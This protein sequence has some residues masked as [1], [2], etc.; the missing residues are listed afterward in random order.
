V[1][2]AMHAAGHRLL[3]FALKPAPVQVTWLSYPGSTGMQ[4]IDYRLT[5]PQLDPP[6][7]NDAW[8]SEKSVHLPRTYWCYRSPSDAPEVNELPALSAGRITFGCLNNFNKVNEV[9]LSAWCRLL[10][11]LPNA[12]LLLHAK[13]GSHR[14]KVRDKLARD[15]IDPARLEFIGRVPV[16]EY[17]RCYHRIDIA[18][19]TF[20][21]CGGTTT[22][23]ALWMGVPVVSLIG[24]TTVS[25]GGLTILT[26]AGLAELAA[27]TI[28]DYAKIAKDL[29]GDLPRL[30]AMRAGLRQRMLQSP[31]MDAPRFAHDIEAAFRDMWRRWCDAQAR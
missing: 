28:E 25:R 31:L 18:L 15:G 3:V 1:D 12:R 20:P 5:D 22:C 21:F 14:Q 9:V 11:E 8:Y 13:E 6:C 29:A 23:D 30:A 27:S 2:L 19:D 7:F 24:Q 16:A 10:A 4:A 17:F 26:N